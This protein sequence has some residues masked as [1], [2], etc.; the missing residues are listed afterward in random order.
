L[1][2]KLSCNSRVAAKNPRAAFVVKRRT[3]ICHCCWY[4]C[5][6]PA[7]AVPSMTY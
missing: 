6:Q 4:L 3:R 5:G 1:L 7:V 2:S